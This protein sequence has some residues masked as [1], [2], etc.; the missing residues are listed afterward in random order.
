MPR[1]LRLAL[2][3][4]L[5]SGLLVASDAVVGTP[6]SLAAPL[7]T[8]TFTSITAGQFHTCAL[9]ADGTAWCWGRDDVGQLGNG[10]DGAQTV[11]DAVSMPSGTLFTQ[12]ASRANH[13]CA[14][15]SEGSAYCWGAG[16]GGQLGNGGSA[17]TTPFEV[18]MPVGARFTQI[19]TGAAHT[20]ALASDGDA[21]CWGSDYR[22]QQGNGAGGDQSTPGA[23]SMPSGVSF[24]HLTA[25]GYHTCAVSS[26]G[27]VWCWGA[28]DSGQA[29]QQALVAERQ[30]PEE[31]LPGET[32]FTQVVA[33]TYHTCALAAYG[34]AWCWGLASSGQIGNGSF[35]TVELIPTQVLTIPRFTEI[36]AGG[37]FTCALAS[38]GDAYCWGRGVSGQ[39]G[40]DTSTNRNVPT[41]VVM[42]SGV[43]FTQLAHG[44][45]HT[46][47]L[48]ADGAAWCWGLDSSGQLGNGAAGDQDVPDEVTMPEV[49]V[50]WTQVSPGLWHTCGLA[51]DGTAWCWGADNLG[52]LGDG[53]GVSA[54]QQSPLQV[55]MPAGVRFTQVSS[56]NFFTCALASDGAAWCWGRDDAGQIGN[57]AGSS[58]SQFVPVTVD[59]PVGVRFTSI[60]A[61]VASACAVADDGTGWCW[62]WDSFG[63]LGDGAP[64][65]DRQSPSAMVMPALGPGTRLFT[66]IDVAGYIGCAHATDGT[67]WCWGYDFLG[68][69][70][71]GAGT[72]D[73]DAPAAVSMPASTDFVTASAGDL[74]GCA[75]AGDGA[76]WCWGYDSYGG[77]GN[78]SSADPTSSPDE[79]D[80]PSGRAFTSIVVGVEFGCALDDRG[81]AWCW[82]R[83]SSY[84]IGNGAPATD[85]ASPSAV[86]MPTDR[87]FT[88]IGV[89]EAH[90][91]AVADDGTAWCWGSD[92]F[93]RLGDGGGSADAQAPVEVDGPTYEVPVVGD[94]LTVTKNVAAGGTVTS[95][96]AGISCGVDCTSQ[97]EAFADAT[98]DLRATS[99]PG[100]RFVR[101]TGDCA[102]RPVPWGACRVSMGGE[103]NVTAVFRVQLTISKSLASGGTVSATMSGLSC[104]ATCSSRSI[105]VEVG[106]TVTFLT[107]LHRGFRLV[108]WTGCTPVPGA[109]RRCTV[110]VGEPTTVT[111]TYLP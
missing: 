33:G 100:Y 9:A 6:R 73:A 83:D 99:A 51:S 50:G 103:R 27:G 78:G 15:T 37:G 42:P 60:D 67:G 49:G 47:A 81:E 2:S 23:V 8:P 56:G 85:V 26:T 76:G 109:P 35:G 21:W 91:C 20:C 14:L 77:V 1:A 48:A 44:D 87:L 7:L 5:T 30:S 53:A 79:V 34:Q 68:G 90:A 62:G 46:C 95:T 29:G 97:T 106:T 102:P 104:A 59:M 80:M 18:P 45:E 66:R 55:V 64:L 86:T 4:T 111:A 19:V 36:Q 57:G 25:G 63:Q 38:D 3:L 43:T 105:Y 70:G 61:G 31:V 54:D 16:S 93:G 98:V 32:Y 75:I 58:A 41:P 74:V 39:L 101:W 40:D 22:G 92:A 107:T 17:T 94:D 96:P 69:L 89:Y 65:T 12:I 13:T 10:A 52:Q 72:A 28:D 84:Q 71:N 11:P 110:T 24:T 82:G 108:S 88:S